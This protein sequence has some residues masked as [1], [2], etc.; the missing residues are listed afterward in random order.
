MNTLY[1]LIGGNLGDRT[2]NLERAKELIANEIGVITKQSSIYE[3]EAWGNQ[4]QR[5]FLNQAII[6]NSKLNASKSMETILEIEYKMGRERNQKNDPRIIDID[7]LFYNNE[8]IHI[9]HLT[10]PHPQIQNR[11]FVL[12][13]LNEIASDYIHP[14][15]KK[16]VTELLKE[17]TDPLKVNKYN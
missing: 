9:S 7:I 12:V 16:T 13:P 8:I 4:D 10:V 1:L 2:A 6:V 5:S 14:V 15:L 11:K 3:T 17:C